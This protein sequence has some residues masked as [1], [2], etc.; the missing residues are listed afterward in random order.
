MRW[1]SRAPPP[2]CMT[3]WH[4]LLMCSA[5]ASLHAAGMYLAVRRC[6]IVRQ[7]I[8]FQ[9]PTTQNLASAAVSWL[10]RSSIWYSW[11][12][13][14]LYEHPLTPVCHAAQR[15]RWRVLERHAG[16]TIR[17]QCLW[18][19]RR[20]IP[21]FVARV[22]GRGSRCTACACS[23]LPKLAVCMQRCCVCSSHAALLR[24]HAVAAKILTG[25]A[26]VCPTSPAMLVLTRAGELRPGNEGRP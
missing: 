9:A 15:P 18:V 23:A 3:V 16:L 20:V 8:R 24:K 19:I 26:L 21:C 7:A 10:K 4:T 6:N 2:Y 22:R 14:Q 5:V 25:S 11:K 13:G 17:S 1:P 12:C